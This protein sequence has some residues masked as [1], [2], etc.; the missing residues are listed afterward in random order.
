MLDSFIVPAEWSP[1]HCFFLL[2][3]LKTNYSS[4]TLYRW[5]SYILYTSSLSNYLLGTVIV[6]LSEWRINFI[7]NYALCNIIS[8]ALRSCPSA[9][10]MYVTGILGVCGVIIK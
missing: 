9:F 7:I 2:L 4:I 1:C 3:S 10:T 6:V 5:Q 8:A